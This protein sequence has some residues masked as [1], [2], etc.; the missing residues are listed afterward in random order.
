[1]SS[2]SVYSHEFIARYFSFEYKQME[3]S[4]KIMQSELSCEDDSRSVCVESRIIER[5]DQ[6]IKIIQTTFFV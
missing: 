2:V 6:H 5:N 1:M 4:L 3:L